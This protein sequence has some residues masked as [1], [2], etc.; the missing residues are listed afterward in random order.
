MSFIF[1]LCFIEHFDACEKSHGSRRNR[2]YEKEVN[3]NESINGEMDNKANK[4]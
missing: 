1:E 2:T 3:G 4:F